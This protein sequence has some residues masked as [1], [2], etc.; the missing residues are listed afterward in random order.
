MTLEIQPVFVAFGHGEDVDAF[1]VKVFAGLETRREPV[2]K[3]CDTVNAMKLGGG[4]WVNARAADWVRDKAELF[5]TEDGKPRGKAAIPDEAEAPD[6]SGIMDSLFTMKPAD[7]AE[8]FSGF[9]LGTQMVIVDGF[10]KLYGMEEGSVH[11][12]EILESQNRFGALGREIFWRV[13]DESRHPNRNHSIR[14]RR[15]C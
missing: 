13:T 10:Y 11:A 9:S 6:L 7:R 15:N 12:S 3:Y 8:L 4:H 2:S 1:F 5:P 14:P